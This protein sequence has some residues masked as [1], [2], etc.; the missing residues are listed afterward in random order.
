M[1]RRNKDKA[2]Q[3][4]T[5]L[6]LVAALSVMSVTAVLIGGFLQSQM[7]LYYG[8][9]RLSKAEGMCG[10]AYAG[11]EEILSYGYMYYVDPRHPGELAYYAREQAAC[12]VE[13]DGRPYEKLPPVSVWPR[14]T[15]DSLKVDQI[16]G[17]TVE[18]DFRGTKFREVRAVIRIM[19]GEVVVYEQEA[20]IRSM[21]V[22]QVQE[23]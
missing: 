1:E 23:E 17:M 19:K 7:R 16:D 15:A 11:L 18:L 3:G 4:F 2:D 22:Y 20:V 14:V 9:E 21:Y 6:E 5:L 8:F 13:T 12:S 10:Q